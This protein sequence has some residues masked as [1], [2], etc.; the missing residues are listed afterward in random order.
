MLRRLIVSVLMFVCA[1]IM[2]SAYCRD[3][4]YTD[5]RSGFSF[6]GEANADGSPVLRID[7]AV[8]GRVCGG[9][10]DV[11]FTVRLRSAGKHS[12][13]GYSLY[14]ADSDRDTLRLY[15]TPCEAPDP[16]R[17]EERTQLRLETRGEILAETYLPRNQFDNGNGYNTIGVGR[18]GNVVEVTAGRMETALAI[19]I[20]DGAFSFPGEVT[21]AGIIPCNGN[22][23][24]LECAQLV[25]VPSARWRLSSGFTESEIAALVSEGED[26]PCGFWTL[27]DFDVDDRYMRCG[28]DYYIAVVKWGDIAV[29]SPALAS[30][31]DYPSEAFA[32]LYLD[33]AGVDKRRWETGMLKGVMLPT[34]LKSA[35]RLVWFDSTGEAIDPENVASMSTAT[36]DS[37][38]NLLQ[39]AFPERYSSLRFVRSGVGM[40]SP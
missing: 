31:F 12:G 4:V 10:A 32:I 34:K 9:D 30:R 22:V 29:S 20:A 2:L 15:V 39:L 8:E 36:I 35:W 17:D 38:G 33:G 25:S 23:L 24:E 18:K 37:S 16:I 7:S 6:F 5:A 3:V 1:G 11:M 26:E 40:K 14:L 28:G 27:L 21:S 13:E 19:H